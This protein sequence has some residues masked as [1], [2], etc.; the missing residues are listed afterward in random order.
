MRTINL[1]HIR[2]SPREK[3]IRYSPYI[4]A[5]II[6][7][8]LP[9]L[10]PTYIHSLLTKILIFAIFAMSLDIIMGYIGLPSLG[11]AA[12]FGVAGYTV[13]ILLVM[14][15]IENFWLIALLGILMAVLAAAILGIIALR[16][17]G[18]YFLLVTFAIGMLIYSM[19]LKWA[20][21]TR[22]Y[23]GIIV[24]AYPDLGFSWFT[25]NTTNYY[26][27]I[28]IFFVICFL[29]MRR[30]VNSPFGHAL[31]GI[32]E[33]EPRMRALGYNTW[34]YKYIAFIIAGLFAGAAGVLFPYYAKVMMPFSVGVS[35][36][37][38]VMLICIIGG[39]GTLWGPVIGAVVIILAEYLS[40]IYFPERWPL[41]LGGVF[42]ITVMFVRGGIAPHLQN[43]WN[44]VFYGSTKG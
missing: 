6:F 29:L 41:I 30:L 10:F 11:H 42:V 32:R 37:T 14:H 38:L 24:T 12:F 23:E 36:S 17:S 7:I 28:F 9:P 4:I 40:S 22:G 20:W 35:A 18:L 44:R 15:G 1:K 21:L 19:A 16:V 34:L 25:W 31:Q 39:L 2:Q 26:Y 43:L 3:L 13:S 8:V 5:G 33:N 27:F